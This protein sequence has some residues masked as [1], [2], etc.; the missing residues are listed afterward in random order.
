MSPLKGRLCVSSHPEVVQRTGEGGRTGQW[1]CSVG[2]NMHPDWSRRERTALNIGV[3]ALRDTRR[4]VLEAWLQDCIWSGVGGHMG[5]HSLCSVGA[6][7]PNTTQAE[8]L[9]SSR[10]SYPVLMVF[11]SQELLTVPGNIHRNH[12]LF[13]CSELETLYSNYFIPW[14]LLAAILEQGLSRHERHY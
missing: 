13:G 2:V 7:R 3:N 4:S 1:A 10:F 9:W 14:T 6:K 11:V 12:F 8:T 5:A